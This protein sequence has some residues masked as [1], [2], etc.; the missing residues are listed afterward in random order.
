MVFFIFY[1]V[2]RGGSATRPMGRVVRPSPTK[3]ILIAVIILSALYISLPRY[4][5]IFGEDKQSYENRVSQSQIAL[6][7]FR[8]HPLTGVGL[9]QYL[10]ELPKYMKI[11]SFKDYQPVHNAW[12]LILAEMGMFGFF[13]L[14]FLILKFLIFN[15]KFLMKISNFLPRRQAGK[16]QIILIIL[17]LSLF[18]HYFYTLQQGNL[19]IGL[20]IG[21]L[22]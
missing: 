7:M 13:L 21:I 19:L 12:L 10:V 17:V 3:I 6:A 1:I 8:D 20:I 14:L 22:L 4:L 15:F 11:T 2:R 18:D 5:S 16:F 9:N